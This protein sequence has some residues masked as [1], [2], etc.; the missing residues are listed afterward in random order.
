[1]IGLEGIATLSAAQPPR[2]AHDFLLDRER[3]TQACIESLIERQRAE[4]AGR[5]LVEIV[6]LSPGSKAEKLEEGR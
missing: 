3:W 5:P 1:M 6:P 2:S 4:V